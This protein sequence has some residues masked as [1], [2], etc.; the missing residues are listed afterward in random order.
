[1]AYIKLRTKNGVYFN[2]PLK[3]KSDYQRAVKLLE[4]E[5]E[6]FELPITANKSSFIKLKTESGV[7]FNAPLEARSDYR[8]VIKLLEQ[9][10]SI[11]E[12]A[13]K[14]SVDKEPTG[15][16]EFLLGTTSI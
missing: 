5:L 12:S 8:R 15:T 1:M 2:A 9:E 7:E 16:A 10:M 13:R 4:Q 14:K 11:I 3:R 6:N